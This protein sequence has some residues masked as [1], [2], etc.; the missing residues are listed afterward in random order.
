MDGASCA[1]EY[2]A[3]PCGE[4]PA[5]EEA[6]KQWSKRAETLGDQAPAPTNQTCADAAADG[7]GAAV[8]VAWSHPFR[9]G[10]STNLSLT[11][12]R[13]IGPFIGPMI[14]SLVRS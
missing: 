14:G 3:K 8:S 13:S 10:L 7:S 1:G 11:R 9:Q 6:A 12:L 5:I 2:N 4:T